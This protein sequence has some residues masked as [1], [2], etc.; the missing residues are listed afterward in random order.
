MVTRSR[1]RQVCFAAPCG[2]DNSCH[3]L[4][5]S[6]EGVPQTDDTNITMATAAMREAPGSGGADARAELRH[7]PPAWGAAAA[8]LEFCSVRRSAGGSGFCARRRLRCNDSVGLSERARADVFGDAQRLLSAAADAARVLPC[9]P[10]EH[11]AGPRVVS[12]REHVLGWQQALLALSGAVVEAAACGL[13]Q[14]LIRDRQMACL[15]CLVCPSRAFWF[16]L[17]CLCDVEKRTLP[18]ALERIARWLLGPVFSYSAQHFSLI[19]CCSR[20]LKMS[21]S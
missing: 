17:L 5:A 20:E 8:C 4:L 21:V 13:R 3:F 11:C 9:I 1:L 19:K 2:F 6:R 14:G 16:R 7:T 12:T 18:N 15:R 10:S